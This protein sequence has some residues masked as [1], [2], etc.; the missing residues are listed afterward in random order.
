MPDFLGVGKSPEIEGQ[1]FPNFLWLTFILLLNPA[2][3]IP[4]VAS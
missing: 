1:A 4:H 3:G 2:S